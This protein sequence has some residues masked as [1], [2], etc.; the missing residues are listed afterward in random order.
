M[1]EDKQRFTG[2]DLA[3]AIA[4]ARRHFNVSRAEIG[5]EV[6]AQT[7]TGLV[8]AEAGPKIEILAWTRP[9]PPRS[10]AP[11]DG[12]RGFGRGRGGDRG[13]G[14]GRGS[15][16]D[17]GR[18]R[19][20]PGPGGRGPRGRGDDDFHPPLHER[21]AGRTRDVEP[22]D[23]PPLLPGP[24]VTDARQ[25]LAQLAQSLITGLGLS[26]EMSGIEE[27]PIGLR[28]RLDGEDVPLLLESDAEGLDAIQYL[29]NRI[30][31]KDGRLP[32]RVSFDA[33]DH[34]AKAE[35]RLIAEARE[36]AEKA[37]ASGQVQKMPSLGPYERRLVHTALAD[38]PGIR[39]FSTGSGYH[40]R[41]H[42]APTNA[43]ERA[44]EGP[45]S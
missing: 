19:R 32:Q 1:S 24:D 14:P 7:K 8:A 45:D 43:P 30:L 16:R 3:E 34:R 39:T 28:V 23:L 4:A 42:I 11:P 17:E 38:A 33:G 2:R 44:D 21:D 25:I 27:N 10:D 31:Q 22:V 29:A 26:L 9:A 37:R 5:Y 18:P 36:V 6:V 15:G 13:R 12:G 40:R 20:G 35:A 41:L